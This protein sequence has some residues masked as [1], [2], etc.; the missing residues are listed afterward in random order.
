M[1]RKF[2]EDLAAQSNLDV[3]QVVRVAEELA[4][5]SKLEGE[6]R[7]DYGI[8][9][10]LGRSVDT[11]SAGLGEASGVARGLPPVGLR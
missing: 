3:R 8:T 9:P 11:Q 6:E 2:L 10:P 5:L 4:K 1:D 7:R